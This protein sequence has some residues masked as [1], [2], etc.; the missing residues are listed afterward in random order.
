VAGGSGGG[1]SSPRNDE[2]DR[3][4]P[5]AGRGAL[6]GAPPL[7]SPVM[8]Y[9]LCLPNFPAGAS[10]EGIEAAA[11]AADRL[12]WSTVW[13]TDHL[14]VPAAAAGEYGH[15][16]E[17]ILTLAWVG[18][19]HPRL[20]LGTSVIVVPQRN[21][22]VLA[23]QLA[24]LDSLSEGRVIAGV[25]VGWNREEFANLGV[26]E[27]FHVRGAYLD[28]TIRL[29]R[30]LWS[31]SGDSFHGRFHSFD[32]FTFSPLPVQAGGPP[33]LVGGRSEPALRRAGTLGD[34]YHSSALGPSQ[35]GERLPVVRAAADAAGRPMP[36]LSAR[37]RVEFEGSSDG[38]A[39]RGSPDE[40]AAEVR[41]FADLGVTHLALSFG[42]TDP[43]E[44]VAR[45]ERFAGEVAPLVG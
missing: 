26:A 34:G 42:T 8:D 30:H 38:Y 44:L 33:I 2:T 24:T 13:T 17:A 28:E 5:A 31:G 4:G 40:V 10:P 39:M 21:A 29:W 37:V 18:A 15:I 20:R 36:S 43:A 27:R 1:S 23:K 32:D 19:R 11:D 45:A 7:P 35:F 9:G 12:G 14:M 41:A 6:A 3:R 22:L 25:G 16:Y